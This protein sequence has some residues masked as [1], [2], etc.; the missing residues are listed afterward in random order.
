MNEY[1][2]VPVKRLIRWLVL[3][4]IGFAGAMIAAGLLGLFQGAYDRWFN[5]R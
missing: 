3:L 5:H 4:I 1:A 2:T